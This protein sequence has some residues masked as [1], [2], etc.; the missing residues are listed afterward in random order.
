MLIR[1]KNVAGKSL[2]AFSYQ[3]SANQMWCGSFIFAACVMGAPR[4]L[5]LF[6]LKAD[7]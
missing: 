5:T 2:A 3:L 1:R 7:S 6:S 4:E